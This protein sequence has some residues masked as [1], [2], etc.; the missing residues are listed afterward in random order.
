MRALEAQLGET[1]RRARQRETDLD[2]LRVKLAHVAIKEKETVARHRTV[3]AAW[4]GGAVP[5][6]IAPSLAPSSSSNS[7]SNCNPANCK[8]INTMVT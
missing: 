7:N 3:L 6:A 2:R 1:E 8:E 5:S 4:R